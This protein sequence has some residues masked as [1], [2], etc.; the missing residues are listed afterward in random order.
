MIELYIISVIFSFAL[1]L[2]LAKYL[3]G[4]VTVGVFIV[5]IVVSAIPLVNLGF[6]VVGAGHLISKSEI[7]DKR[8]F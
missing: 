7:L 4:F 3:D 5:L 8:I 2:V 6:C 1:M